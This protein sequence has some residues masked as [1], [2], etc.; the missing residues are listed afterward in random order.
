VSFTES[1]SERNARRRRLEVVAAGAT[2]AGRWRVDAR[3]D[4][5]HARVAP[6][7]VVE[8]RPRQSLRRAARVR[9]RFHSRELRG[10]RQRVEASWLGSATSRRPGLMAAW[11]VFSRWGRVETG[12]AVHAFSLPPG[13]VG[14]VSRPGILGYETVSAVSGNGSD[15]S[16]RMRVRL[17]T[18]A[19]LTAWAGVPRSGKWRGY[20]AARVTL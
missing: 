10:T 16:V 9:A 18:Y 1:G 12:A 15:L 3:M 19:R 11:W 17:G 4:D 5:A 13:P 8:T 20:L 6:G 7:A 14:Y 2:S